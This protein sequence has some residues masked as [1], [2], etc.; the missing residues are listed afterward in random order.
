MLVFS[1]ARECSLRLHVTLFVSSCDLLGLNSKS[2]RTLGV[3]HGISQILGR[4]KEKGHRVFWGTQGGRPLNRA[5]RPVKR[6][7][8]SRKL[9][10]RFLGEL[11][12]TSSVRSLRV[13]RPGDPSIF[14]APSSKAR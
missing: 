4:T 13:V 14:L 9:Q 8:G 2:H 10:D 12:L 7:I 3:S 11:D 6:F 5:T 1:T